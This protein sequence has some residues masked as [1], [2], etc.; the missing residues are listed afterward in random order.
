MR[1]ETIIS[2]ALLLFSGPV[3]AFDGD[4]DLVALDLLDEE[5]SPEPT[6]EANVRG[7]ARIATNTNGFDGLD[8][9]PDW[10]DPGMDDFEDD[11]V[12]G[13]PDEFLADPV[14]DD[15]Y[16]VGADPDFDMED[17]EQDL[18]DTPDPLQAEISDFPPDDLDEVQGPPNTGSEP[19][20]GWLDED[21]TDEVIIPALQ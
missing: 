2:L 8:D 16:D 6:Q 12:M 9:D 7:K 14:E 21:E 17:P 1:H 10:D 13:D 19:T 15:E 3:F 5:V 18:A 4:D 11:T 20:D